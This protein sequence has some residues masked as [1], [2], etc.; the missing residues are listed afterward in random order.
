MVA[1]THMPWLVWDMAQW[2]ICKLGKVLKIK[3]SVAKDLAIRLANVMG[4][5]SYEV[6]LMCSCPQAFACAY[7]LEEAF[8]KVSAAA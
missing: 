4:K 2:A 7:E 1:S 6:L 3:R 5:S 8:A